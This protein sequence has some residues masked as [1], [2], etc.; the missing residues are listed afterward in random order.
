MTLLFLFLEHAK[1]YLEHPLVYEGRTYRH[2][3]CVRA[4]F[5][6]KRGSPS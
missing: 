1:M 3:K 6:D 4:L 2:T 5:E